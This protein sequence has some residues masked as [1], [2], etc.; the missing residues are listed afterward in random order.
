MEQSTVVLLSYQCESVTLQ[1]SAVLEI[2]KKKKFYKYLDT[3]KVYLKICEKSFVTRTLFI[4]NLQV[5]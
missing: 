3:K 1:C 4:K 5:S 2:S